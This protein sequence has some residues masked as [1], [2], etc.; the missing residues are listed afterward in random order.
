MNDKTRLTAIHCKDA[1]TKDLCHFLTHTLQRKF[2]IEGASGD[3]QVPTA[4]TCLHHDLM[5]ETLHEK[6][7]P[8]VEQILGEELFPTYTYSRLYSNGDTLEV[9]TDRPACEV[10]LTVQLGRSHH[11]AWPICM[12]DK[13]FDM[14]EGDA[15]IYSGCDVKHWR[16]KCDGPVGYYSGQAFFHFVRKDGEFANHA[17]DKRDL[18]MTAFQKFRCFDME[19]K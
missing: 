3:A 17:F 9:H 14:A 4:L 5:L 11:Y 18:P 13:R 16:N 19:T 1:V 6:L 8:I 2:A 10:S 15:V 7:W 12:G